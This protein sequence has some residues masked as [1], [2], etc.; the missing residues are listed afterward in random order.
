[1]IFSIPL[2]I[3]EHSSHVLSASWGH[4][5][6]YC[7]DERHSLANREMAHNIIWGR[8]SVQRHNARGTNLQ[9][10]CF[11]TRFSTKS[12]YFAL[13]DGYRCQGGSGT[14]CDEVIHMW[15]A[16]GRF[17]R[18]LVKSCASDTDKM[19]EIADSENCSHHPTKG[20]TEMVPQWLREG[21][22]YKQL[23]P[24]TL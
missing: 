3:Y 6:K 13:H 20:T 17:S 7:F 23:I 15:S 16:C 11:R 5:S 18:V 1:M 2:E 8:S 12:S 22:E 4:M 19:F 21:L 14:S 10:W 9:N 24:I